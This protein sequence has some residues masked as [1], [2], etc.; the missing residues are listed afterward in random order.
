MRRASLAQMLSANG[1]SVE[2][3]ALTQGAQDAARS[4]KAEHVILI[5]SLADE[6]GLAFVADLRMR[7]PG[8]R[9]A[10]LSDHCEPTGLQNAFAAG[11][12]AVILWSVKP[13]ALVLMI[14]LLAGGE[15]FIPSPLVGSL[16]AMLGTRGGQSLVASHAGL[17]PQQLD[18]LRCLADGASNR[19]IAD[20]L[21]IGLATVRVQVRTILRK[22]NILNRTQAAIW[23]AKNVA[24]SGVD[25]RHSISPSG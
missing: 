20:R 15:K 25:G 13:G 23:A 22:L 5:D 18:I 21:S 7:E 14:P 19:V 8:A 16:A 24:T 12:D 10:L 4:G 6:F 3:D 2:T 1:F 17:S 9:I 11:A